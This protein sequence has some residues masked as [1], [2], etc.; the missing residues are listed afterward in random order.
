[1]TLATASGVKPV[2]LSQ[3]GAWIDNLLMQGAAASPMPT[4]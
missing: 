4:P 2:F 1:M 3:N